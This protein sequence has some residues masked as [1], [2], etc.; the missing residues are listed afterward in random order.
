MTRFEVM[1]LLACN[2]HHAWQK[3][4]SSLCWAHCSLPSQAFAGGGK[5]RDALLPDIRTPRQD[6]ILQNR[7]LR[8][9]AED[10]AIH[11]FTVGEIQT[12]QRWQVC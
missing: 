6:D 12:H 8:Q 9:L 4:T 5:A 3:N 1:G 11:P 7:R 10:L 2:A